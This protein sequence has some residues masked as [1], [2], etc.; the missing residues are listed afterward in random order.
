MTGHHVHSIA[1]PAFASGANV[2]ILELHSFK[3]K[4]RAYGLHLE[5]RTE[6]VLVAKFTSAFE[7]HRFNTN[8]AVSSGSSF[9]YYAPIRRIRYDGQTHV[10]YYWSNTGV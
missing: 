8:D 7:I 2:C 6:A 5:Q 10:L 4:H 3:L 1:P 9:S